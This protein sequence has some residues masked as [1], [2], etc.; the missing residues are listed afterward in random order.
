MSISSNSTVFKLK[1]ARKVIIYG[2]LWFCGVILF[3]GIFTP[4]YSHSR[5]AISELAA[6]GAPYAGLVQFGG[7]IPLGLAFIWAA[8]TMGRSQNPGTFRNAFFVLFILT[9]LAIIAAG[10]FPTDVHGRRTSFS[11]MTHAIAGLFLLALICLTPLMAALMKSVFS[12]G[13]RIYSLVSGLTLLALFFL[14]PNGISP[15]L[16]QLQKMILGN[17]FDIWYKY[18]GIDQRMLFLVYFMW[19][20]IFVRWRG[21]E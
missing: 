21:E 6:P 17:G 15:A 5:Q 1:N 12:R 4:G 11:G 13:F 2:V 8:V 18:Q 14:L 3:A 16:I 20:G 19:L 7:F 9:G 10:I